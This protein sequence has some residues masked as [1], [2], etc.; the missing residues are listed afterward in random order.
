MRN[1]SEYR[2]FLVDFCPSSYCVY[3]K[4]NITGELYRV[5]SGCSCRKDFTLEDVHSNVDNFLLELRSVS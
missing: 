2:G 5:L 1:S 3:E 4:G